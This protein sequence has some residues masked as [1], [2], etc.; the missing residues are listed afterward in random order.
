VRDEGQLDRW[1]EAAIEA[2]PQAADDFRSGKAA[3]IGRLVGQV[4]KVSRGQADAK[5]AKEKLTQKLGRG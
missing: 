1:C 5:A 2:Q 3:A 4:M